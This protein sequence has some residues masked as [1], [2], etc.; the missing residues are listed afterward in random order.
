MKPKPSKPAKKRYC[1]I[2]KAFDKKG[3]LIAV[4]TNSYTKTHPLMLHFGKI[5]GL[6]EKTYVHAEVQALIRS[7]DKQVYR[8]LVERYES[9]GTPALAKPC[10]VCQE[11]LKAYGV[12]IVEYTTEDGIVKEYLKG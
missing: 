5:A 4:G 7:R 9:D 8:L 12:T 2:A 1:I 3:N 10:K 6:P 11:A